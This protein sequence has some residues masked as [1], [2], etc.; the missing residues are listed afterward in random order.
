MY[1]KHFKAWGLEKNLKSDESIAMIKIAGKRRIANKDTRFVRRGKPVEP[2]K[3][4]RFA[5][6]HNLTETLDGGAGS[7]HDPQGNDR[8]CEVSE[9][10]KDVS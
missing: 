4:R 9:T 7:V 10:S 8:L 1:K 3:L 2:A 5:K 6:R